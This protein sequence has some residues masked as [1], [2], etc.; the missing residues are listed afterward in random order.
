MENLELDT[1]RALS[2]AIETLAEAEMRRLVGVE[3]QCG[4][5]YL[6]ASFCLADDDAIKVALAHWNATLEEAHD[7]A[8]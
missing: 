6:L 4:E 3:L 1:L 7:H 8:E 5:G 2:D